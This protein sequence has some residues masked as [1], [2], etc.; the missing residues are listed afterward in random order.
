MLHRVKDLSPDQR[1]AVES[2]LG[3]S[4]SE[5]ESVS[6]KSIRPSAMIP[7]LLS[8]EERAQAL[9]NLNAYFAAAHVQPRP[10]SEEEEEAIINQALRTTRPNYRPID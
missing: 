1:L 2:L 8:P 5:D 6:V 7:P 9:K 10:V 4:V 3:R